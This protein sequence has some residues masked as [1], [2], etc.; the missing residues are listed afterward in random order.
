MVNKLEHKKEALWVLEKEL[1]LEKHSAS[2]LGLQRASKSGL[3][4]EQTLEFLSVC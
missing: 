4:L 3:V 1:L 2:L